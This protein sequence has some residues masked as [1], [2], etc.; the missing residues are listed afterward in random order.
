M[1]SGVTLFGRPGGAVDTRFRENRKWTPRATAH[2]RNSNRLVVDD[3][4]VA[5]TT[6]KNMSEPAGRWSL[7]LKDSVIGSNGSQKVDWQI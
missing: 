7:T 3:Y 4:I 6:D 5:L 1:A 2:G